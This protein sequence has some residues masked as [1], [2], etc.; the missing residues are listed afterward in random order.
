MRHAARSAGRS[1]S[2][3]RGDARRCRRPRPAGPGRAPPAPGTPPSARWPAARGSGTRRRTAP[4]RCWS[5]AGPGDV[6][7]VE[8]PRPVARGH[9]QEAGDRRGPE[10]R[11]GSPAARRIVG[12]QP[13]VVAGGPAD[14]VAALAR[15]RGGRA[16]RWTQPKAVRMA[17]HSAAVASRPAAEEPLA[18]AS[19]PSGA[20]LFGHARRSRRRSPRSRSC[21]F[22]PE[23]S[24]GGR[25]S[26][27]SA[28][29]T[30][31]Q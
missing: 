18:A 2:R 31:R 15:C 6:V 8:Q 21:S 17:G 9:L 29:R 28:L 14:P 5:A 13:A 12:E 27:V 19:A 1:S 20:P 7:A 16:A 22:S 30:A 23:A 25:P 10:R 24:S 26:S 3:R 11:R 4:G